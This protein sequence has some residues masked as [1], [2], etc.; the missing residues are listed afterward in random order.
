[1]KVTDVRICLSNLKKVESGL[2]SLSV[3]KVD[4]DAKKKL[5]SAMLDVCEVID[6]LKDRLMELEH[7]Q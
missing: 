1:M 4:I 6:D 7:P 5:H 2:S 3:N